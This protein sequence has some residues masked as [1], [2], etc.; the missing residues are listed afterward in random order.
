[1]KWAVYYLILVANVVLS[2]RAVT[3]ATVTWRFIWILTGVSVVALPLYAAEKVAFYYGLI[4]N[5]T[6]HFWSADTFAGKGIQ[7]LRGVVGGGL[8]LP[9]PLLFPQIHESWPASLLIP[10]LGHLVVSGASWPIVVRVLTRI[11]DEKL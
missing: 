6:L 4:G 8:L 3:D 7:R 1:M 10:T 9:L 2:W 11:S 5:V